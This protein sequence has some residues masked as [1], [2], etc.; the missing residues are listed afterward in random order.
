MNFL[1]NITYLYFSYLSFF[2]TAASDDCKKIEIENDPDIDNGLY[3]M[4]PRRPEDQ[5]FK[6]IW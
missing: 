6:K 4:Y 2:N 1:Y 3:N 5:I